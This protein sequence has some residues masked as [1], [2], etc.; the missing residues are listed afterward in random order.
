MS[1]LNTLLV[2]ALYFDFHVK[3]LAFAHRI[4]FI[5]DIENGYFNTF[6]HCGIVAVF[7]PRILLNDFSQLELA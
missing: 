3:T 4:S 1:S 2:N 6:L 5:Y 7:C